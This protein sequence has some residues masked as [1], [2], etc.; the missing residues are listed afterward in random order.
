MSDSLTPVPDGTYFL[1]PYQAGWIAAMFAGGK[2]IAT[3]CQAEQSEH[4][5]A[6][7]QWAGVHPRSSDV[8]VAYPL[9]GS[10]IY[11]AIGNTNYQNV[12]VTQRVGV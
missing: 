5:V 1:Q 10:V 8:A 4:D 2:C 9:A 12:A 11:L 3:T 6:C 7:E